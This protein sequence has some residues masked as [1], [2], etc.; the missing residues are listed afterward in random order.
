MLPSYSAELAV[1]SKDIILVFPDSDLGGLQAWLHT[2]HA[3][4]AQGIC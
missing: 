3:Y 2:Y 1:W 4:N